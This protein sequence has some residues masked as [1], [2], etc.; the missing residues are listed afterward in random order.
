M[1]AGAWAHPSGKA[2]ELIR[3]GLDLEGGIAVGFVD[4]V[5]WD[6]FALVALAG[7]D[8]V[9]ARA[10]DKV[11]FKY[12]GVA[13]RILLYDVSER[14]VEI[15]HRSAGEDGADKM[16][17]VISGVLVD[18]VPND[19][20]VGIEILGQVCRGVG[21]K[22]EGGTAFL[23]GAKTKVAEMSGVFEKGEHGIAFLRAFGE[24]F[25]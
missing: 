10:D 7:F 1:A 13:P 19:V 22:D 2:D 4:V 18:L 8:V 3:N 17:V 23:D 15:F 21:E 20:R 16:L 11:G 12:A 9:G 24:K 6:A 5:V 14:M 25:R